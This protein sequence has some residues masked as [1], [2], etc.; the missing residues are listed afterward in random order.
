VGV[1]TFQTKYT[2]NCDGF[3]GYLGDCERVSSVWVTLVRTSARSCN[4]WEFQHAH[5][6]VMFFSW[7]PQWTA[8]CP[9]KSIRCIALLTDPCPTFCTIVHK[10]GVLTCPPVHTVF[11]STI[12]T[13]ISEFLKRV[14]E[15]LRKRVWTCGQVDTVRR[16]RPTHSNIP[17]S[18]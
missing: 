14:G 12:P 16:H 10:V 15:V 2:S 5:R 9:I 11:W 1:P 17:D 8:W 4:R 7:L 3:T 18:Q 13:K 6:L